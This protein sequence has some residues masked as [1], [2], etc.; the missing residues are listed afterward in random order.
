MYA[1]NAVF[2]IDLEKKDLY[3]NKFNDIVINSLF[4]EMIGLASSLSYD[5]TKTK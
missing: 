4:K 1:T 3:L 5:M 2:T